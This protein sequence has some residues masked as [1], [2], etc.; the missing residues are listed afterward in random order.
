[1]DNRRNARHSTGP[2]TDE[3]KQRWQRNAVRHGVTAELSSMRLKTR[4]II[5]P[6]NCPSLRTT[7]PNRLPKE[8]WY[9]GWQA[10][11]GVTPRHSHRICTV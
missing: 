5:Q 7:M 4:T 1:M 11:C 10:S 8:N 9:S 2:V 6:S 3:G